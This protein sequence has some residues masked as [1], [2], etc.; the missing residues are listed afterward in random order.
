MG[1]A[2]SDDDERSDGVA[3]RHE[4]RL[5]LGNVPYRADQHDVARFCLP[6]GNALSVS[7]PVHRDTRLRKEYVFVSLRLYAGLAIDA[8][9]QLGGQFMAVP[10]SDDTYRPIEVGLANRH[11]RDRGRGGEK[12]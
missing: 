12:G 6:V 8:W 3:V 11:Q 7:L 9:R 4:V 5:W 2:L 10:G 1:G